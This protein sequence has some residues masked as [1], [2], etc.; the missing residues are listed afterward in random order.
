ME[1]VA[2][3][4]SALALIVSGLS[5]RYSRQQSRSGAAMASIEAA[6]RAEEVARAAANEERAKHA[7]VDVKLAPRVANSS[8]ELI[9]C[10]K[11][12]APA[13]EVSVSFVRPLSAGGVDSAFGGIAQRHFDLRPGDSEVLRLSADFDTAPRYEVAVY[14]T[15]PAG[16]HELVREINHLK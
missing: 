8:D 1:I 4:I 11:G 9:V 6:R 14:W 15:D 5:V 12:P 2:L 7:D 10:N 13:S 3:L 16:D